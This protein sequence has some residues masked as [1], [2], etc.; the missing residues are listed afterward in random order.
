MWWTEFFVILDNFLPIYPIKTRKI[1]ILKTWKEHPE[2]SSF[3]TSVPKIRIICY[4][5]PKIWCVAYVIVIFHF[6]LFFCPFTP[7]TA[8]KIKNFK[9][10]KKKRLEMSSFYTSAPK[11]MI[12][13]NTVPEIWHVT[14]VIVIFH[15]GLFFA[16]LSKKSKFQKKWKKCLEIPSFYTCV[17][18][19]MI[20][21]CT[22]PEKWRTTDEQTD[23]WKKWHIEV[24]SPPKNE[25]INKRASE[26]LWKSKN[27][28]YLK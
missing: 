28:L 8:Q 26:I 12:I 9:N 1:K 15:F 19:T 5:V 27:L 2:I 20:R 25:V 4:T 17:P 24:G 7:L 10:K 13:C 11:I 18:K 6:G 21:W 23:R 14:H 16:L 22:V 3:Y